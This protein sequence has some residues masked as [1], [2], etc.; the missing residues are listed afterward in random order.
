MDS[1]AFHGAEGPWDAAIGHLPHRV[2]GRLR[3]Q[4]DEVPERVMSALRLRDLTVGLRL[5]SVD[6][7]RELD[8]VLDEEDRDVVADEIEDAVRGV[9]L[10][11]E[12]SGV[13]HGIG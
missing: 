3:V 13:S 6:D 8:G 4:R 9:E 2:V 7:I 5:R 10:R 1:E 12:A 11:G